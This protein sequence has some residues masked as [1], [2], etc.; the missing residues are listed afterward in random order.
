MMVISI[1]DEYLRNLTKAAIFQSI[2]YPVPVS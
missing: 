1:N 2:R